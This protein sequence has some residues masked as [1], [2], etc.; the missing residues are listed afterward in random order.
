[1]RRCLLLLYIA[2]KLWE[3]RCTSLGPLSSSLVIFCSVDQ[4]LNVYAVEQR[5]H[6]VGGGAFQQGNIRIVL[7]NRK[8]SWLSLQYNNGQRDLISAL[9]LGEWWW[10]LESPLS[11]S[12][13]LICMNSPGP[14]IPS[15]YYFFQW[16]ALSKRYL[17]MPIISKD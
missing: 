2:H 16:V 14:T 13:A 6:R 7:S 10:S 5:I 17:S 15:L 12:P 3:L 9:G 1:M 8:I 4:I 11:R